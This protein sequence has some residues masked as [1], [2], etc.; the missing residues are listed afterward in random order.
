MVDEGVQEARGGESAVP[1]AADGVY[2]RCWEYV[3]VVGQ[4]IENAAVHLPCR[5]DEGVVDVGVERMVPCL[6]LGMTYS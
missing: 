4:A 3:E 6:M 2:M 1:S 5:D